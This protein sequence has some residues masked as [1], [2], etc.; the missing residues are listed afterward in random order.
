MNSMCPPSPTWPEYND[1]A[2]LPRPHDTSIAI[3]CFLLHPCTFCLWYPPFS[4]PQILHEYFQLPSH[5][6]PFQTP[7]LPTCP[8]CLLQP[9][10]YRTFGFIPLSLH[11]LYTH[12]HTYRNICNVSHVLY[13][14]LFSMTDDQETSGG[15]AYLKWDLCWLG[16]PC[17]AKRWISW[18]S[19]SG[20]T[21]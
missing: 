6:R 13:L 4:C 14:T 12:T 18:L 5:P 11:F 1:A 16:Q 3:P 17:A 8:K 10:S 9:L 21:S 19:L 15:A 7:M 20:I 2:P